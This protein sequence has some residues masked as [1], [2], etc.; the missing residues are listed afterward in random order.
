ML[1]SSLDA[2]LKQTMT[3]SL[4]ELFDYDRMTLQVQLDN[5]RA[6]PQRAIK[7][8]PWPCRRQKK[9]DR[10]GDIVGGI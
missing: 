6:F 10:E 9:G 2:L 7:D 8:L 3:T 1:S 4:K 5:C